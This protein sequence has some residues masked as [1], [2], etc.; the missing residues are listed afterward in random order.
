MGCVKYYEDYNFDVSPNSI[1]VLNCPVN[2][3]CDYM[4]IAFR[5]EVRETRNQRELT[6]M[7]KIQISCLGNECVE[8][9]KYFDFKIP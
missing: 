9:T 8:N 3:L 6:M 7:W 1:Q 2:N 4:E 5:D